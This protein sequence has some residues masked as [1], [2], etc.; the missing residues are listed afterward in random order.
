MT[1]TIFAL[2]AILAVTVA[3]MLAR[4]QTYA[5]DQAQSD[6]LTNYLHNNLLP[7]VGAEVAKGND[8]SRRIMLYG[9]V[10][11][12]TAA[13]TAGEMALKYLNDPSVTL[14]NRIKVDATIGASAIGPSPPSAAPSPASS[15]DSWGAIMDDI[16]QEGAQTPPA[17]GVP[18]LP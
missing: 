7:L 18:T 2:L 13:V 10:A 4:A 1:R 8:G 5:V 16:Y 12:A 11:N 15:D 17:Q 3:P 6:G 14:I 9:F